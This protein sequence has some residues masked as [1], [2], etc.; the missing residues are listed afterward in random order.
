MNIKFNNKQMAILGILVVGI[1]TLLFLVPKASSIMALNDEV[2]RKELKYT[3]YKKYSDVSKKLGND[4]GELVNK[5]N[6]IRSL[7]PPG[8][9]HSDIYIFVNRLSDISGVKFTSINISDMMKINPAHIKS[10]KSNSIKAVEITD[11]EMKQLATE[12][13][14]LNINAPDISSE[15][16][17]KYAKQKLF[18]ME[19]LIQLILNFLL[20]VVMKVIKII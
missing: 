6:R 8:V 4:K 12:L 2:A 20:M 3:E 18:G 16:D 1:Y 7:Y 11:S 17:K 10:Q 14:F 15:D 9:N 13:G 19:K 5:I